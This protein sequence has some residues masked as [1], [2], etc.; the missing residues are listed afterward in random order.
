MSGRQN[1]NLSKLRVNNLTNW[2]HDHVTKW[3]VEKMIN[4]Q[5]VLFGKITIQQNDKNG[6]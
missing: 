4:W 1:D 2:Q 5:D 6:S 3:L